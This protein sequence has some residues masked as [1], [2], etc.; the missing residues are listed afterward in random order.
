[1]LR[2]TTYL[3]DVQPMGGGLMLWPRSHKAVH[4]YFHQ[5]PRE[6]DGSFQLTDAFA[7]RGWQILYDGS[8]VDNGDGVGPPTEF[9][10]EP[11]L[12]WIE[13]GA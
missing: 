5:R 2:F 11:C 12:V 3:D 9:A 13:R 4:R 6:I 10:G 7:D 1:M 8:V